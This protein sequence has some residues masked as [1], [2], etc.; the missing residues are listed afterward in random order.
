MTMSAIVSPRE[1]VQDDV[2]VHS[3]SV[4]LEVADHCHDLVALEPHGSDVGDD[5]LEGD[6][7]AR[8]AARQEKSNL[9]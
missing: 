7:P 3:L 8:R 4:P 2:E 5:L 1:P 6:S 9:A